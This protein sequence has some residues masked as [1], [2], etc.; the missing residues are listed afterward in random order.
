MGPSPQTEHVT[1]E[2]SS[3]H[4]HHQAYYPTVFSR[5]V[6]T[7]T[8]DLLPPPMPIVPPPPLVPAQPLYHLAAVVD[9]NEESTQTITRRFSDGCLQTPYNSP[10]EVSSP[11][12]AE[13]MYAHQPMPLNPHSKL[14]MSTEITHTTSSTSSHHH[15]EHAGD[16]DVVY[17]QQQQ[18]QQQQH[19]TTDYS[20]SSTG[21]ENRSPREKQY[22]VYIKDQHG[23]RVEPSSNKRPWVNY[24][25]LSDPP[26]SKTLR[27]VYRS[28]KYQVFSIQ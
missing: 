27:K 17:E 2:F 16:G 14:S 3:N 28:S 1:H 18:E 11:E 20:S 19:T 26:G 13:I 8:T 22:V 9:G 21:T 5:N 12:T 6:R 24:F 25:N 4:N 10:A 7:S 15:Q 23:N